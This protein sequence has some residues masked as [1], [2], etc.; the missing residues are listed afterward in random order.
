[1]KEIW[2]HP[3]KTLWV[4]GFRIDQSASGKAMGSQKK[5]YLVYDQRHYHHG[6]L[7]Q[8][9]VVFIRDEFYQVIVSL[10]KLQ[11]SF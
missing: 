3:G 9:N 5:S 4:I 11:N 7:L 10:L 6:F 2:P 1:M 8:L